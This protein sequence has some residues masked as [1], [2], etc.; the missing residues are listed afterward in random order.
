MCYF[1]LFLGGAATKIPEKIQSVIFVSGSRLYHEHKMSATT[2]SFSLQKKN[3]PRKPEIFYTMFDCYDL[4]RARTRTL[5]VLAAP[6][7][8]RPL[9][10]YIS[11]FSINPAHV[12]VL[13]LKK[14]LT[15]AVTIV[16]FPYLESVIIVTGRLVHIIM[17]STKNKEIYL[18]NKQI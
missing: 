17:H 15:V 4:N 18:I 7:P 16:M 3:G 2:K 9:Q 1:D 11:M 13:W 6:G 5:A 8:C 12:D 10:L 14:Y